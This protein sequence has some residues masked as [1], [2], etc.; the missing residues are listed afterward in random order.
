MD[1]HEYIAAVR[2]EWPEEYRKAVH[3][4][5]PFSVSPFRP[6][7]EEAFWIAVD[8][9]LKHDPEHKPCPTCGRH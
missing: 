8:I 1:R 6:T 5:R 9:G 2:A 4:L 3:R 7:V